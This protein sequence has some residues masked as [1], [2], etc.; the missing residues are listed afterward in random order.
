MKK[1]MGIIDIAVRLVI[2]VLLIVLYFTHVVTGTTGIVLLVV[3][4][5]LIL[6]SVL[7]ICPMYLPFN[8]S[9]RSKE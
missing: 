9:T 3:A 1:N 4:G 8:L 7:G 6:T 2:A 5:V